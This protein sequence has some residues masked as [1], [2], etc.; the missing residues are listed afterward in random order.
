MLKG[1]KMIAP[2]QTSIFY[3][4]D[5]HAKLINMERTVTALRTFGK[6]QPQADKLRLSSGDFLLGEYY[7]VNKAAIAAQN[8]MGISASAMGNHEYDMHNRFA[9][10]FPDVRYKMLACNV[11]FKPENP[12]N[13]MVEKSYIEEIN[14][15]KYGIVGLSPTDLLNRL[16]SGDLHREME[17]SDF[18]KSVEQ[19]QAEVDKLKSQGIDKIILLSHAGY[20][21]DKQIAVST[22]GI[23]IIIGG[24]S[25]DLI[26]GI[27]PG[28]NLLYSKTGKPVVIV[29][30]GRD[31]KYFGNL[32]VEFNSNGE[33]TKAQNNVSSTREFHRDAAARYLFESILGKPEI[34]GVIN[35]APPP[36]G[37]DLIEPNGHANFLVDC[38]HN[39]LG[40]DISLLCSGYIRGRFEKG[41]IDSRK[42]DEIIPFKN[43]IG[44][45]QYS[46]K[47]VIDALK[48]AGQSLVSKGNKPGILQTAGLKYSLS[49]DGQLLEARFTDKSGKEIPI[50]VNNPRTDKF[51]RVG[52]NDY[53]AEGND[54]FSMLNTTNQMEKTFDLNECL[55]KYI[56][57]QAK[58]INIPQDDGRVKIVD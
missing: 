19:L 53:M 29:Q 35:S 23:D 26:K 21:F 8:I 58:L 24:H 57:S 40:A 44:I 7:F 22:E 9:G 30:A 38:I 28:E 16:A 1:Y 32:N 51:Y 25:H 20:D 42:I 33:I 50:D 56:K 27:T 52:I 39:A 4:N 49:K 37:N 15:H 54:G 14:G 43:K 47:Q 41:N 46:E 45:V 18:N 2:V 36:P 5:Y 13:K 3:V 31:G 55:V 6:I 12:Y 48:Y 10:L 11:K 34:L 17:V